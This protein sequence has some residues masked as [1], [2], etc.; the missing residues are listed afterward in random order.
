MTMRTRR[1][2]AGRGDDDALPLRR[3][4]G[5]A[6]R[7]DGR[8]DHG[9]AD[10]PG[11]RAR[12]RLARGRSP[13]SRAAR[14]G[15][16]KRHPVDGRAHGRRGRPGPAARTALRH[17]EQSL[18]SRPR[19]PGSTTSTSQF[20]ARRTRRRLRVRP[21]DARSRDRPATTRQTRG[22]RSTR[23]STTCETQLA[24]GEFPHLRARRRRSPRQFERFAGIAGT[25]SASSA[26]CS[27]CSTGS[28]CGYG[29]A[30]PGSKAE[31][32]SM[33]CLTIPNFRSHAAH[34]SRTSS[35][36]WP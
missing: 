27:A 25:R 6:V 1:H 21:R 29:A 22:A 2:R 19:S 8:R 17:F 14:Y 23:C 7:A 9:R 15:V 18:R 35:R 31:P 11:R 24:T 20:G 3:E 10:R 5:R 16:F 12:R 34:C 13:R 32:T 36:S 30:R 28:S 4:Q 33:G 26:A